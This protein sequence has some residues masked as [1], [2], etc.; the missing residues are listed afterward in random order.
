MSSICIEAITWRSWP[1][2]MSSACF[3]IS[4][5]LQ[6]QQADG[7]VLHQLGRGADG[8]GEHAGHVHADVLHRKRAASG[9]SICIGSRLSQA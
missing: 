8:H 7:R 3:L 9:I 1:K 5:R 4:P 2:M 6:A